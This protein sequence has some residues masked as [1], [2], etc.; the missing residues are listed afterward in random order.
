MPGL[1]RGVREE[2]GDLALA[3]HLRPAMGEAWVRLDGAQERAPG[4]EVLA[5]APAPGLVL[6]AVEE[7]AGDD[8]SH[9]R[10]TATTAAAAAARAA[11]ARLAPVA[12]VLVGRAAVAE[13]A[14]ADVWLAAAV[15]RGGRAGDSAEER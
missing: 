14:A 11:R 1:V 12:T 15:L 7:G 10:T 13:L 6:D 4:V 8:A 5:L 2:G 3:L 9:V